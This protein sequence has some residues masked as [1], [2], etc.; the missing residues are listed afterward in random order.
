[1]THL[2]AKRLVGN[3]NKESNLINVLK[4]IPYQK[5]GLGKRKLIDEK[6]L[7][8]MQIALKPGQSVPQHNANSNVQ[9]LVLEGAELTVTLNEVGGKHKKGDLVPVEYKTPMSIKNTGQDNATFLVVK[10]PNPSEMEK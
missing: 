3:L 2:I 9:L 4:D 8:V 6:H 10:T 1:M 7:L 5:E